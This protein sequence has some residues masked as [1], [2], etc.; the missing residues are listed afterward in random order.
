[1]LKSMPKYTTSAT[2]PRTTARGK[3]RK[4]VKRRG[5]RH[6]VVNFIGL[7]S[8]FVSI[9]LMLTLLALPPFFL[10]LGSAILL[11]GTILSAYLATKVNLI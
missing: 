6:P 11:V 2:P 4:I 8:V 1:M 3:T 10:Q 7:A 5:I 9:P